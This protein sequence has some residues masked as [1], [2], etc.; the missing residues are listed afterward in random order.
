MS[1]AGQNS[2]HHEPSTCTVEAKRLQQEKIREIGEA[3]VRA[4]IGNL[5]HQS[6]ALNVPRSTAWSILRANH[7]ASGLSAGIIQR[8]LAS[9]DLPRTVRKRI[10]EYVDE[11]THGLY[12]DNKKRLYK[13]NTK[14][15]EYGIV[16]AVESD[17]GRLPRKRQAFNAIKQRN[18]DDALREG[19]RSRLRPPA[20]RR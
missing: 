7:K 13:F 16:P 2:G 17:R 19:L 8:M 11:K 3:L 20:R 6:K 18:K 4:G 14:L 12:G 1:M 5:S 10:L 15:A 9:P